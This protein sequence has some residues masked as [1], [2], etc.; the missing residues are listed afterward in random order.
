MKNPSQSRPRA[1]L[2]V[3]LLVVPALLIAGYVGIQL[4]PL[5]H[6]TAASA[7]QHGLIAD[8]CLAGDGHC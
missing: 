3:R 7:A 6:A 2:I 1:K 8:S 4:A 5:V